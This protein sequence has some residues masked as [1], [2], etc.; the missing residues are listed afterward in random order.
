MDRRLLIIILLIIIIIV[1]FFVLEW[2]G[3]IDFIPGVGQ[4]SGDTAFLPNYFHL[5]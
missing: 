5:K 4:G 2:L 1:A 3:M